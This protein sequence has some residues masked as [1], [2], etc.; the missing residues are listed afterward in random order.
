MRGSDVVRA[1]VVLSVCETSLSTLPSEHAHG[2]QAHLPLVLLLHTALRDRRTH[3]HLVTACQD[4]TKF[5]VLVF[6][7]GYDGL[8]GTDVGRA[9]SKGAGGIGVHLR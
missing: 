7:C 6:G 8:L 4:T 5:N 3:T 2:L 9:G 1:G